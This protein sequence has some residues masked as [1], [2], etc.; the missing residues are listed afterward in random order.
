MTEKKEIVKRGYDKIAK[1]YQADRHIFDNKRELEEFVSLLP[2]NAKVLD[3]GCGA[4]VPFIKFLVEYGCSVTGI[5]FSKSMLKLAKRNVPEAKF[6]KQ[7]VTRLGLKANSFDG[8]TSSYCII[9]IPRE[10]HS[11]LFQSFHRILKPEGVML[12]SMGYSEWEGTDKYYGV[13]MFWSHY[14]PEKSLQ[15][16]E[17]AG[18]Q[19]VWD[20]ITECGGERPYWILA[21]NKK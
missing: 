9:H 15:T 17:N 8:L 6:I 20:E 19:T 18:F 16:I 2:W 3:I 7:D 11:S 4:A 21:R 13:N 1:E 14:S 12:I 5:D 10:K